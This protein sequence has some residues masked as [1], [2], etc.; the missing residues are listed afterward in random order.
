ME[1]FLTANDPK[2]TIVVTHHAP[3]PLSLKPTDRSKWVSCAYASNLDSF[4]ERFQP[5]LWI[6]GHVHHSCDYRIGGTRILCNPQGYP[7][8][9]NSEFKADL[10]L[11]L[12]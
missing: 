12:P 9:R 5:H 4:I 1:A 2:K 3:S 10:V 11:D 6:H 8:E 7:G